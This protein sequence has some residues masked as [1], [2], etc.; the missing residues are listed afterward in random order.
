MQLE[1]EQSPDYTFHPN[2]ARRS[3]DIVTRNKYA[4]EYVY[5]KKK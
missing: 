4:N 2:L 3:I 5:Y 1:K